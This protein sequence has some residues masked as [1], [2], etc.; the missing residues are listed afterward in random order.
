MRR[1]LKRRFLIFGGRLRGKLSPPAK[2]GFCRHKRRHETEKAIIAYVVG[3]VAKPAFAVVGDT[4][5]G[6]SISDK[7]PVRAATV[8]AWCMGVFG[9]NGFHGAPPTR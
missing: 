9:N 5:V 6:L 1:L 2:V 3:C 8:P 4:G 7:E